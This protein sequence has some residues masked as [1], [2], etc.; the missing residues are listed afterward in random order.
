MGMN[1]EQKSQAT[2]INCSLARFV[3]QEG[4]S[5]PA[6][7]GINSDMA[8]LF[9]IFLRRLLTH[10]NHK[11]LEGVLAAGHHYRGA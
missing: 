4:N 10:L 6:L 2:L 9:F 11:S 8:T 1:C 5:K 3:V 7:V